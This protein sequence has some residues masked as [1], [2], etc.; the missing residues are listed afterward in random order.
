MSKIKK[1]VEKILQDKVITKEERNM[2]S[3]A[4]LEDGEI[5]EEEKAEVNRILEMLGRGEIK[6]TFL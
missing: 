5:D 4:M 6:K 3:Q 1:L 2:L